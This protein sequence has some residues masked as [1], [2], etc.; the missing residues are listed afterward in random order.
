MAERAY[1]DNARSGPGLVQVRDEVA[2]LMA[3]F[4]EAGAVEV[5]PA[6]L[7]SADILLDLYGE[8][9]RAR[10]FVTG[11]PGEEQVLRPD[12]TV[13]IVQRHMAV[14]AEPARY[15]YAGSVWR[16]QARGDAR[17]QEYLQVGFEVFDRDNPAAS[18]AEVFALFARAL[19]G[20]DLAVGTGDI[21][22]LFAAIDGLDTTAHRKAALRRHV[23]RPERFQRLVEMFSRRRDEKAE[24][25][26]AAEAIGAD[27]LVRQAGPEIGLRSRAE[28]V[29][30]ISRLSQ[31]L[32]TPPLGASETGLLSEVLT[33]R[34]TV[35]EASERLSELSRE[36]SALAGAAK[37]FRNRA[38]AL[39]ARGI[40]PGRLDFGGSYG[41]TTL[42]Y[43]D[44]FVFGFA[45]PDRPDLP[46]IASGGRYDALT[47]VLG[48]GKGIPA[49]GGIVRPE[50]LLALEA[51]G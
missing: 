39:S 15:A 47:R 40:D 7:L 43:Y 16:R 25:V 32:E 46:V 35:A 11:E 33:L 6:A 30:R 31:E 17:A 38:D 8:D 18:D 27:A 28:V 41:R 34:G 36:M 26:A 22:L 14:G 5:E 19:E 3:L 45:A 4:G 1:L 21:G 13:P 10:A 50:A 48:N 23:W 20:H 49:V 37:T 24:L 2:R 44:G 9:I 12:F 42:E 29:A 51:G